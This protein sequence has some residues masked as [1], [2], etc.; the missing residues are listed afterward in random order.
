M[1]KYLSG[2]FCYL[3]DVGKVRL[4]NE[5]RAIAY[6]N[7]RGNVLLLV[8]DGMG[9]A[10][11]GD[12]A[13]TLASTF[14]VD[15]FLARRERF[16]FKTSAANWLVSTIRKAN[17][18]VFNESLKKEEYKGMGTTLTAVLLVNNYAVIA[19]V[20]DSRAYFLENNHLVQVSE[21]QTY[22]SH[23]IRTGQITEEEAKV[24]PKRHVLLNALGI[25]P[26]VNVD[27]KIRKYEGN[28]ILVCSDGLYN[29]IS[30]FDIEN[31]LKNNDSVDLKAKQLINIANGNGGS[32]NIAVVLWEAFD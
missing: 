2:T 26:S 20:G 4:T 21:D 15:E 18:E 6:T 8:C 27:I 7:A 13:S 19:Q 25:Y 16:L 10:S 11:K 5:D 29:N 30:S 3:T 14:I 9:G 24:H 12:L 23:L 28:K 31:I 32:D 17:N 22:V 1:S